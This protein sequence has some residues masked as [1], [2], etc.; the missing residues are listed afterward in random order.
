MLTLTALLSPATLTSMTSSAKWTAQDFPASMDA[1]SS[2]PAPTAASASPPRASSAAPA[3]RRARRARH[4]QGRGGRRHDRRRHRGPRARPRR[5]RVR[6]R[7]RRRLGGR[8][9]RARSTTPASWRRR[10]PH[11]GRLRAAVRH[12]PPR[13]LRAHRT[14]CS[15]TS[16]TAWSSSPR[17]APHRLDRPRRPQLGAP[18]LHALARLRAVQA[19]QPAVHV[20]APA[21]ARRGGLDR[22]RDRRAPRLRR[23]EPPAPHRATG[24]PERGHGRSATACWP[25]ARTMGA[26]PTLFAATQDLPGRHATSAPTASASSAG[27]RRSWA[28]AARRAT[29]RPRAGCGSCPRSSPAS[30]SRSPGRRLVVVARMTVRRRI[31]PPPGRLHESCPTSSQCCGSRWNTQ[32][33][34]PMTIAYETGQGDLG[35]GVARRD[36]VGGPLDGDDLRT[37]HCAALRGYRRFADA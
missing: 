14:C 12:Q 17:G 10:A 23:D 25:R 31:S 8:P 29:R 21:A 18:P 35:A 3:P 15:T 36:G 30:P 19:R 2:S 7:L 16:P 20:R 22:P 9:R 24:R 34:G 33:L 1:P 32:K 13:P 11:Q 4:R 26:L 6:P 37:A 27:T 5:P 28:A